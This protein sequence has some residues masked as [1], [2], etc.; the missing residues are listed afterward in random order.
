MFRLVLILF[1]G[2]ALIRRW[3]VFLA[4]GLLALMAGL[5]VLI[6]LAD[7]VVN[8][9]A[10]VLGALLLVLGAVELVVASSQVG[11]RRRLHLFRGTALLMGAFLVLDFPWNNEIATG[12]LFGL[13]F[14]FNGL[15]RIGGAL[16]IRHA[17]WRTSVLLGCGYLIFAVLLLTR[18]PLADEMNVSFCLGIALLTGGFI[19]LRFAVRVKW[20]PKGCRLAAIAFYQDAQ[21][22]EAALHIASLPTDADVPTAFGSFLPPMI[23][24]VWTA[25]D[26]ASAR[27]RL[28]IIERYVVAVSRKG[29]AYSGHTAL[30]NGPDLYISHHPRDRLRIGLDN[31]LQ[32]AQATAANNKPGHWGPSYADEA[33]TSRP[34]TIQVKFNSYNPHYLAAFWHTYRQDNTYNFARRNCS[35]VVARAIDA[36]LEG[37][38][39]AK[40]FW[41]TL[42]WLMFHPD[43]WMA[44]SARL[45]AEYL[46]WS[47]G[48]V[49]DY[50]N[51][52]RRITSVNRPQKQ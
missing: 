12:V 2:D 24:H 35:S 1:G 33:G 4:L 9:S 15:L 11:L 39:A 7:G 6:D 3:G 34:S 23:V 45:R 51:A 49:L 43:I 47:P 30:E 16:L 28:P 10:H 26:S 27:I 52:M 13:A 40:P 20:L 37:V 48:L 18:W 38:F 42:L 21:P 8:I 19:T 17:K 41:R 44:A 50:A 25:V 36:A 46:A 14:I 5:V 32:E 22:Q 29:T 31:V